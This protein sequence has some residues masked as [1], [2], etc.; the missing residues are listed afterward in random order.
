LLRR[1][2]AVRFQV[3]EV[4]GS[5]PGEVCG[6]AV[7]RVG[8]SDGSPLPAPLRLASEPPAAAHGREVYVAGFGGDPPAKRLQPGEFLGI[9]GGDFHHDCYTVPGSAGSPVVDLDEGAVLGLHYAA[10]W[11]PD[12]RGDAIALWN[13]ARDTL[14]SGSSLRGRR[15]MRAAERRARR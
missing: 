11:K 14:L 2:R 13:L 5:I 7:L 8:A 12:K 6:V 10:R 3:D 1:G 4:L 15:P 9:S